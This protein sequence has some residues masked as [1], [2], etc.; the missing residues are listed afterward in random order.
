[1]DVH[2]VRTRFVTLEEE[3]KKMK[4]DGIEID[5]EN[6]AFVRTEI[7]IFR[8]TSLH[9]DYGTVSP[10]PSVEL[11]PFLIYSASLLVESTPDR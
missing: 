5:V 2:H 1:M 6:P 10:T 7:A 4:T 8:Q 3:Y 9:L 11:F